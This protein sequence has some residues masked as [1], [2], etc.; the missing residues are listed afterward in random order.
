MEICKCGGEYQRV[1]SGTMIA[2]ASIVE[3]D[4][5][6]RVHAIPGDG[7]IHFYCPH[8]TRPATSEEVEF[9]NKLLGNKN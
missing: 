5:Q 8:C 7:A 4:G 6:V 9:F 3:I 2:E 1:R